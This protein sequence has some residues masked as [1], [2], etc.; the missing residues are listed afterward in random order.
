MRAKRRQVWNY[1]KNP[2][3]SLS[4]IFIKLIQSRTDKI[5]GTEKFFIYYF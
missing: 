1:L 5:E 4:A 2:V 3:A